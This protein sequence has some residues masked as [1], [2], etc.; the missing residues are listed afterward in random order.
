VTPAHIRLRKKF[1]KEHERKRSSRAKS[2][3]WLSYNLII[4]PILI[5]LVS[6]VN[7]L[8]YF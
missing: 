4:V 6:H 5:I 7:I 1:L 3:D 8:H 2:A